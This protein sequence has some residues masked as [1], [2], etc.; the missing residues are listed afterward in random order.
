MHQQHP[1]DAL[2]LAPDRVPDLVAAEQHAG[3][4]AD[5]GERADERIGHDLEGEGGEGLVIGALAFDGLFAVG[6]DAADR[7]HVGGRRQVI[8]DPVEQG[9]HP[10]VLEGG[11]VEHG[12]E[13]AG[14]GALADA[15]LERRLVRLLPLEIDLERAVIQFHRRLDQLGTVLGGLF[16]EIGGNVP[17]GEL[18]AEPLILPNRRLHGDEIDDTRIVGLDADGELHHQRLSAQA[19]GDHVD[20]AEEI[21]A[22]TVHLVDETD[23][24]DI[25]SVGL[26]PDRFR[27]GFDAGDAVEHRHRAVKHPERALHLDGEVD[28]ARRVDDVDAVALPETGGGGGGN[29]DPALLLLLHPV[30]GGGAVMDLADLVGPAGV[31]ED[32]LRRGGLT[33][34]DVG[35]DADIAVVAEW[36][37]ASH[38]GGALGGQ[39]YQR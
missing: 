4:D 11:A 32:A 31:I 7:R 3:I 27:L 15:A 22:D 12:N 25:V 9:L 37:G 24:R 21:D 17:D 19:I 6:H 30:H 23:A 18:G 10:L 16:G 36:G 13:N 39:D 26:A 8:D 35:H 1:P 33:G 5:E 34:I 28:M 38:S 20:A 29:G 2:A 14:N